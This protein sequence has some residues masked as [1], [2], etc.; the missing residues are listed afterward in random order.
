MS[1]LLAMDTIIRKERINQEKAKM[2]EKAIKT[3]SQMKRAKIR[4]MNKIH[5]QQMMKDEEIQQI[6]KAQEESLLLKKDF[7]M[8]IDLLILIVL[9]ALFLLTFKRKAKM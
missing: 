7:K 5:Q 9:C 6:V 1:I 8:V 3:I 4:K 2:M